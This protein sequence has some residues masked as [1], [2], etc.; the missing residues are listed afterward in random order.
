MASFRNVRSVFKWIALIASL[1]AVGKIYAIN[2][3]T[4]AMIKAATGF[5]GLY[6]DGSDGSLT[7]SGVP[8][9]PTNPLQINTLASNLTANVTAGGTSV[10]L[11]SG[12]GFAA[13]QE[14]L[15]I[16]MIGADA[17]KYEFK[18]ISSV[19]SNTLNFSAALTY[20]Y[21]SAD[22]IQVI[23]VMKYA[24]VTIDSGGFLTVPSYNS[25]TGIGGVMAVKVSGI[26]TINNGG[27]GLS[28]HISLGGGFSSFVPRGFEGGTSANGAGPVGG[29]SASNSGGGNNTPGSP[30]RLIMGSGGGSLSSTGGRGGGL[31][32]VN[33]AS[34]ILNGNI[35]ADGQTPA[36]GNAGGGAGGTVFVQADTISTSASCGLFKANPGAAAGTGSAGGNGRIFVRY[37][38][39]TSCTSAQPASNS[40][41]E[42]MYLK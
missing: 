24:N 14:V 34:I 26:L 27:A 39:S 11:T 4:N 35:A 25:T 20:G 33:A 30:D 7:V 19:V 17:G 8:N 15:I 1:L 6:G 38:T 21:N 22:K 37:K 10:T 9:G 28:G 2:T 13:G 31:A 18:T 29:A 42:K 36:A 5:L 3:N 32:F 12:A 40:N 41:F 23:K 16:Q